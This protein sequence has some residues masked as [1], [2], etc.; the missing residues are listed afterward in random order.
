[1]RVKDKN[2]KG[3][4]WCERAICGDHGPV[5]FNE[6]GVATVSAELGRAMCQEYPDTFAEVKTGKKKADAGD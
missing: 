1:M 6:K 5:E 4:R 2:G 3:R